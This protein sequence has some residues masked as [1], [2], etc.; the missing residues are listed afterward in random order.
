VRVLHAFLPLFPVQALVGRCAWL[1]QRPVLM[2][3]DVSGQQRVAW[4]S[5]RALHQGI[6][7]GQTVTA[8]KAFVPQ[9][10][11]V[12]FQAAET[13]A[14]LEALG[15][16]LLTL[17]PG[18]QV[19]AYEGLWLDASAAA[20]FQ[21]EAQWAQRVCEVIVSHGYHAHVAVSS[22]V[23][24]SQLLAQR[25]PQKPLLVDTHHTYELLK[26]VTLS[27]VPRQPT[28]L[29]Q[30]L[31]RVGITSVGQVAQLPLDAMALRFA[32]DGVAL[33][34][35]IHSQI[36]WP[37]VAAAQQLTLSEKMEFEYA[38]ESVE[39]VLFA[40]KTLTDRLSVRLQGRKEA[41]QRL[42]VKLLLESGGE[43]KMVLTLARPSSVARL[44]LDVFRVKLEDMTLSCAVTAVAVNVVEKCAERE[45]Q[46][47]LGDQPAQE[48]SLELVL[49]RLA[50]ALGESALTGLHIEQSFRPERASVHR[51]FRLAANGP[52]VLRVTG[53][54]S[55]AAEV[56]S[57]W[58]ERPTRFVNPPKPIQMFEGWRRL[59]IDNVMHEVE[60]LHGPEIVAGVWWGKAPMPTREYFRVWLKNVGAAWVA[61]EASPERFLLAGWFD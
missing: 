3:T 22:Q 41:A 34:R 24:S 1:Q 60:A 23:F 48:A 54:A 40:L 36:D 7:P 31:R 37:F 50:T 56:P 25:R 44:I 15:E 33:W 28:A 58:L 17:A 14:A 39:P 6:V 9:V 43:E 57:H 49:S 27:K 20:L 18:F 51:P 19:S 8:A 16:A 38:A 12:P 32:A 11:V 55:S 35:L 30:R 21:G 59:Q 45:R 26:D 53:E 10:D 61:R 5:T 4:A 2:A 46:L 47:G 13:L 52:N 29:I 42:E